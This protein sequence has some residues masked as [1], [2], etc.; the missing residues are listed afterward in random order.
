MAAWEEVSS[1]R[2][3]EFYRK[4]GTLNASKKRRLYKFSAK[5]I[6][7]YQKVQI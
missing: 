6:I 3:L 2:Y 4:K 5:I 7:G 1:E